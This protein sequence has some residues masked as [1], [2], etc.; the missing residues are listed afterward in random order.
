LL[1]V[2]TR[3]KA[4]KK[5]NF[6]GTSQFFYIK[7]KRNIVYRGN[8]KNKTRFWEGFSLRKLER[9]SPCTLNE[10][11]NLIAMKEYRWRLRYL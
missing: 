1:S 9:K 6:E 2:R 4:K 3:Q 7:I 10:F 11:S 8:N 5:N